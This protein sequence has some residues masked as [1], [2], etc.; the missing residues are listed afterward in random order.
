MVIRPVRTAAAWLGRRLLPS[1]V[2]KSMCIATAGRTVDAAFFPLH[3]VPSLGYRKTRNTPW[4]A[5]SAQAI[6]PPSSSQ[7]K[8]GKGAL[9]EG[10]CLKVQS[11]QII[12]MGIDG[13]L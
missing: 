5:L 1:R 2:F 9:F 7:G 8:R 4:V 12:D 10:T 13:S 11:K 3:E 6:L